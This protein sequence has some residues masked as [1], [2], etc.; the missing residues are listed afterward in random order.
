[1]PLKQSNEGGGHAHRI[2]GWRHPDQRTVNVEEQGPLVRCLQHR[3]RL[4][5]RCSCT[6][7]LHECWLLAGEK[8][9]TVIRS[10]CALAQ[11][12]PQG[13]KIVAKGTA[14]NSWARCT[15][16]L[17]DPGAGLTQRGDPPR[18]AEIPAAEQTPT[19]AAVP[20]QREWARRGAKSR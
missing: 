18:A 14:I 1:E 7:V 12:K 11:A 9:G 17:A 13:Q 19:H 5:H 6:A 15:A 3:S 10:P 2:G 8:E 4:V 16:G 20:A